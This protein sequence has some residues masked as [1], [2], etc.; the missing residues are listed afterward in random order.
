MACPTTGA[1][2]C[3]V[4]AADDP[5]GE[6][7]DWQAGARADADQHLSRAGPPHRHLDPRRRAAALYPELDPSP[8]AHHLGLRGASWRRA[9]RPRS[10]LA[11][12]DLHVCATLLPDARH[13]VHAHPDRCRSAGSK[14]SRGVS[15]T[16]GRTSI[17]HLELLN[18]AEVLSASS[19][20]LRGQALRLEGAESTIVVLDTV[21][22]RQ[23]R[24]APKSVMGMAHRGRSRAR[25]HRRQVLPE[26]FAS[27]RATSTRVGPGSGDVKYHKA[28]WASSRR[29]A[30]T[31]DHHGVEPSH[32]E[33]VDP[34]V[35]ACPAKQ[36]R[37]LPRPTHPRRLARSK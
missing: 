13:R 36:D 37:V 15:S 10:G 27:S 1:L 26:I 31:H 25:Q 24:W 7:A 2:A 35:E 21:W 4:N 28:Q 30:S 20:P 23:P 11:R 34:V 9:G 14:S 12:R 5:R 18:S 16:C 6:H 17:R 33:A 8:T 29:S 19:T 3:D 22:T 32:L